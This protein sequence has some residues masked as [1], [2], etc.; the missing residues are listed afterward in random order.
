MA[1]ITLDEA[2]ID[3]GFW[4]NLVPVIHVVSVPN[5][6]GMTEIRIFAPPLPEA[7]PACIRFGQQSLAAL[8]KALQQQVIPQ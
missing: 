3:D 1:E 7:V 2:V 4:H 6:P 8:I 5:Q